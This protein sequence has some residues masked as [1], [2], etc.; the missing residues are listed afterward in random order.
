MFDDEDA[1]ADFTN[2]LQPQVTAATI[3]Q[4]DQV[5]EGVQPAPPP[6]HPVG[7]GVNGGGQAIG[8]QE[9]LGIG[10]ALLC[11][12]HTMYDPTVIDTELSVQLAVDTGDATLRAAVNVQQFQ[13]YLAML[14]RQSYVIKIY[15]PV[16]Y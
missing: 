10:S 5:G 16:I 13:V 4:G 3:T 7:E 15:T 12:G 6:H 1:A 2:L 11:L 8:E 14:G 9:Y